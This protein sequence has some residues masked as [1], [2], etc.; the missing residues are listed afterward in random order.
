MHTTTFN[1][2]IYSVEM[3]MEWANTFGKPKQIKISKKIF[4]ILQE[5]VWNNISPLDVINN[6]KKYPEHWKRIKNADLKYPILM[7][8]GTIFDGVHRL[9]KLYINKKVSMTVI[10]IPVAIF[11]KFY[12]G[13]KDFFKNPVASLEKLISSESDYYYALLDCLYNIRFKSSKF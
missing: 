3:A 4:N 8:N 2:N 9:A 13:D 11:N 10:V 12:V 1:G 5:K 6:K 7:Y